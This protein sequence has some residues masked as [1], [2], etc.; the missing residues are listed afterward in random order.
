MKTRVSVLILSL[1]V[2]FLGILPVAHTQE[3]RKVYRI[4]WLAPLPRGVVVQQFLDRARELGWVEGQNLAIEYRQFG[5]LDEAGE[6]AADLVRLKVDLIV[7]QAPPAIL[8]ARKVTS[9]IPIVMMYA[10]DPIKMGI[11]TNLARPGGNLTGL[12]FDA[13]TEWVGKALQLLKEAVPRTSRIALLLNLEND[14][15]PVYLKHYEDAAVQLGLRVMP[16]WVRRPEDF[17]AAF[18][19][20]RKERADSLIISP[21]PFSIRNRDRIMELVAR[22]RLPALVAGDWGFA[23]ALLVYGPRVRH[24]PKRTADYVDRILRGAAPGELPIEQPREYDFIVD[25]KTAKA[26]GLTIPQS[27][28][29]GADRVIQ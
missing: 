3:A 17:D 9:T 26:L 24:I 2:T 8:A 23:G 19:R 5:R 10:G 16:L 13:G 14:S 1:A 18:Q 12:S 21:D 15:H 27:L 29:L 11:A 6:R 22:Y 25:L 28:L 4:G 7:A 20:A